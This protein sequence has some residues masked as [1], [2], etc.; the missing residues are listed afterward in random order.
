[1]EESQGSHSMTDRDLLLDTHAKVTKLTHVMYGDASADIPGV[2][3]RVKILEDKEKKRSGIYMMV[4]AVSAGM[5][6][7]I[8]SFT[9]KF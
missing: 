1:M 8:K 4:S 7:A 9:D 6:L 2:A 3:Q 5:A